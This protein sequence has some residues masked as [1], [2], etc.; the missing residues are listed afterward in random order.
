MKTPSSDGTL[1][2]SQWY[3]IRAKR[4]AVDTGPE[5]LHSACGMLLWSLVPDLYNDVTLAF[6]FG[7]VLRAGPP[8]APVPRALTGPGA[9]ARIF[10]GAPRLWPRARWLGRRELSG[11]K[12]LVL[13]LFHILMTEHVLPNPL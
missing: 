9:F 12:P 10:R 7:A 1:A 13:Q 4:G 11:R 2:P 6:T 5:R 3:M 8:A